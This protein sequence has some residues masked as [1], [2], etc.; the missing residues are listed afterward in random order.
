MA[1]VLVATG[2]RLVTAIPGEQHDRHRLRGRGLQ[3]HDSHCLGSN[4]LSGSVPTQLG[5]LSL[6]DGNFYLNVN[7]LTLGLPSQIGKLT[8]VTHT[9]TRDNLMTGSL[10]S[11]LGLMT[12]L[13]GLNLYSNSYSQLIPSQLGDLTALRHLNSND[14]AF[15]GW[16]PSE[17]GPLNLLTLQFRSSLL[18]GP[19]PTQLGLLDS[20]ILLD[21]RSNPL[22]TSLPTQLGQLDTLDPN[23]K[24]YL[25]SSQLCDDVPTELQALSSGML[26]YQELP[27][28]AVLRSVPRRR[29][30]LQPN[31]GPDLHPHGGLRSG[32]VLGRRR[33]RGVRGGQVPRRHAAAGRVLDLPRGPVPQL[34]VRRER[35]H[36]LRRV[37]VGPPVHVR[38]HRLRGLHPR[39]VHPERNG[40]RGLRSRP[41]RAVRAGGRVLLLP[42]GFL[43]GADLGR[44]DMRLV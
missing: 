14:A 1:V 7:S 41:V 27:G 25:F 37:P 17:L 29:L 36:E 3:R 31:P 10:P 9:S 18:S 5:Q 35:R 34:L 15:S 16:Y 4:D 33:V 23:G 38:P 22:S 20:V 8:A 2:G 32:R 30:H 19:L 42:G 6:I 24:L 11:E 21:F 28:H 13:S 44:Q 40:V 26:H 12:C 39:P 43:D